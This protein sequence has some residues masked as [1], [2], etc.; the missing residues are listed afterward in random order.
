MNPTLE[1]SVRQ[2][3]SAS[4]WRMDQGLSDTLRQDQL[5]FDEVVIV[6]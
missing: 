1:R 5:R 3:V 4:A 6:K 2:H